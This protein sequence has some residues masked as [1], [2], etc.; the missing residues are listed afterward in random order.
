MRITVVVKSIYRYQQAGKYKNYVGFI[1]NPEA[2]V[3]IYHIPQNCVG[4]N[5]KDR[6]LTEINA[7]TY[8]WAFS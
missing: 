3:T 6:V 1:S 4:L 7:K 2:F 5:D 8:I